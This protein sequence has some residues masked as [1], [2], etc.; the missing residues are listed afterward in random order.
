MMGDAE[1][2]GLVGHHVAVVD[3]APAYYSPLPTFPI[4]VAVAASPTLRFASAISMEEEKQEAEKAL[5]NF[6]TSLDNFQKVVQPLLSALDTLRASGGEQDLDALSK[7]RLHITLCYTVNTLFCMYL[8]TQGVNPMSHPVADEITRVQDAFL[9]LR[10]VEAGVST[11][12]KPKPKRDIKLHVAKAKLAVEKLSSVVFP[13]EVHLLNALRNSI[14]RKRFHS[15]DDDEQSAHTDEEMEASG[16]EHDVKGI[17]DQK[18]NGNNRDV[19]QKELSNANHDDIDNNNDISR[20]ETSPASNGQNGHF[21]ETGGDAIGETPEK[22]DEDEASARKA[23][24]K[25]RKKDKKK[26]KHAAT[27][28]K[29]ADDAKAIERKSERSSEKKRKRKAP[30]DSSEAGLEKKKKK[31]NAPEDSPVASSEKKKKKKKHKGR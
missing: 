5:N 25:Q 6:S 27:E 22:G 20:D 3:R 18:D 1:A 2:Y 8:R 23:R 15:T 30:E 26:K 13:E 11:K 21:A 29:K 9:R 4:L 17:D 10:K 16:G 28:D 7:A 19:V 12:P 31:G 14:K 24:K